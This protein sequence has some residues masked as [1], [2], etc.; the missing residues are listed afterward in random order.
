[1]QEEDP[2]RSKKKPLGDTNHFCPVALK[3]DGVLF[4]G[5][6]E[7]AAKYREK[8]YYLQSS[9]ARDAFLA[10]PEKYLP[11]NKPLN[12]G[13]PFFICFQHFLFSICFETKLEGK[14]NRNDLG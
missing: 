3:D 1:M 7:I 6:P 9:E 13:F 8:V 11:K 14:N 10:A 4:P 5:N 2:N 12:V